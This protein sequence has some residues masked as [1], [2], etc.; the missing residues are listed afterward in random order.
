MC[1]LEQLHFDVFTWS[2][3]QYVQ[4]GRGVPG[5]VLSSALVADLEPPVHSD[6]SK[7]QKCSLM[8]S[9]T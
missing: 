7:K 4:F 6:L 2:S 9:L 3:T 5:N 1:V 8:L